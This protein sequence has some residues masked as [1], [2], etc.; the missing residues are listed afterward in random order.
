MQEFYITFGVQYGRDPEKHEI[1][2]NG[3]TGNGYAVIEADDYG[4]AH[5]AAFEVFGAR[6]AFAY[7]DKPLDIRAPEGELARFR[8][9]RADRIEQIIPMRELREMPLEDPR[10][11]QERTVGMSADDW[12]IV[13]A[14]IA[15]TAE[16]HLMDQDMEGALEFGQAAGTLI[17]QLDP[18]AWA[19]SEDQAEEL[20]ANATK[21][22]DEMTSKGDQ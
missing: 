22:F 14:A 1:H 20:I 6:W 8:V 16:R 13:L 9:F 4:E 3:M 12:L 10:R 18:V 11:K 19:Q 15:E 21:L 17:E 2:P 7:T 5:D